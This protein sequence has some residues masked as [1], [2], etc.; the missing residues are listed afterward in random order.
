LIYEPQQGYSEI[1]MMKNGLPFKPNPSR[2]RERVLNREWQMRRRLAW[3]AERG[4]KCNYCGSTDRL[5]MDHIDPMTKSPRLIAESG[6]MR[7]STVWSW[8]KEL[9]DAE[10]ALCQV[11]CHRCHSEKSRRE[12]QDPKLRWWRRGKMLREIRYNKNYPTLF[13]I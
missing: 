4:G 7:A 12:M 9:A 13:D 5:E 10:L 1:I 11:L 3:I 8:S 6:G 2:E